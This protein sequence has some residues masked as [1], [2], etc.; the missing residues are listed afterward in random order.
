MHFQFGLCNIGL[1]QRWSTYIQLNYNSTSEA[2]TV[3]FQPLP[4]FIIMAWGIRIMIVAMI[5]PV[6][7]ISDLGQMPWDVAIVC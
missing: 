4:I 1:S 7:S 6:E 3:T 2:T 5:C